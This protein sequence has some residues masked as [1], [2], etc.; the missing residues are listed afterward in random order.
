MTIRLGY[1]L[2]LALALVGLL[3]GTLS[4][5]PSSHGV[6]ARNTS[7]RHLKAKRAEATERWRRS[8]QSNPLHAR[9]TSAPSMLKNITFT[10]P[11]A[12][13]FYVDGNAIPDVDHNIGSSWA[14]LIPISSA[15]NETRRL[16]FWFFLAGPEGSLD[17]IIICKD[18]CSRLNGGPGCSSLE[19]A[20]QENGPFIWP[21]GVASPTKNQW[22]WTNLSNV[23]YIEQ[24]VGTGFTQGVPNARDEGDIAAQFVGF[25]KQFLEVFLELKGKDLFIAGESECM[26]QVSGTLDLGTCAE[27]DGDIANLIYET[28]DID[29][30]LRGTWMN[31]AVLGYD[32]VHQIAAETF[33]RDRGPDFALKFN[34]T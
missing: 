15:Q 9:D 23:L 20:L 13:R 33:L 11:E 5:G 28:S 26:C 10:N 30:H 31:D 1:T 29:L 32:V 6:A 3:C 24:P 22:S 7:P 27:N 17:D 4:S 19:G 16:F 2:T 12:S 34:P 21:K 18:E 14:G 25:L 8:A